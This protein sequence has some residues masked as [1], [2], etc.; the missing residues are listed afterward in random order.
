MTSVLPATNACQSCFSAIGD[1]QFGTC[2]ASS[3]H[4]DC[5]K[6]HGCQSN[7]SGDIY[8][9]DD[10][11]FCKE[12]ATSKHSTECNVCGI[13]LS[14]YFL[15]SG[16]K[17]CGP[18]VEI[19]KQDDQSAKTSS[20]EGC[21]NEIKAEHPAVLFMKNKYHVGC[22]NCMTCKKTLTDKYYFTAGEK[23]EKGTLVCGDCEF[24]TVKSCQHCKGTLSKQA[25]AIVNGHNYHSDCVKCKTCNT[26]LDVNQIATIHDEIYCTEHGKIDLVKPFTLRKRIGTMEKQ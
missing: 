26:D 19:A 1:R 11:L 13:G 21:S 3:Y 18:C 4:V 25:Y 23:E 12:C 9:K 8:P 22:F 2:G 17:Y 14:E 24:K 6:C 16:E 5:F 10:K 15:Y 7:L 20:C